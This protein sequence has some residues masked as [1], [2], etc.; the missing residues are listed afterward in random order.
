[1]LFFGTRVRCL[2]MFSSFEHGFACL[3]IALLGGQVLQGSFRDASTKNIQLDYTLVEALFY[4][5]FRVFQ[6]PRVRA[7]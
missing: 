5:R 7:L 3:G 4:V 2:S 1:M 6:P